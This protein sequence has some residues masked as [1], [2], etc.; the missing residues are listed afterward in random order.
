[1]YDDG[2]ECDILLKCKKTCFLVLTNGNVVQSISCSFK[3]GVFDDGSQA[4][5][6]AW[7][8]PAPWHGICGRDMSL[9]KNFQKFSLVQSSFYLS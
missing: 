5:S 8:T 3:L 2:D 6:P 1:M 9:T 7:G 4:H